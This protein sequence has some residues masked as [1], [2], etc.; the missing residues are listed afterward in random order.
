MNRFLQLAIAVAF[1]TPAAAVCGQPGV[2]WRGDGTGRYPKAHPVIHWSA[3]KNVVW[4]TELPGASPAS[5]ILVRDRLVVASDPAALLCVQAADGKVLWRRG[6]TAGDLGGAAAGAGD[7]S[8]HNPDGDAGSAASTPASDGR[9]VFAMFGNGVVSAHDLDGQRQWVRFIERPRTGYGHAS[10]PALAGGKVIV[11]FVDVVALEA[12]TGNEAWRVKLPATHASPVATRVG[13]VDVIVH[14]AGSIL[15]ASDGKALAEGLFRLDQSSPVVHEGVIY[16]H[17]NGT[18]KAFALPAR[19]DETLRVKPLWETA[20]P[21]GQYQIASPVLHDGCVYG[22]SLNGIWQATDGK[23]GQQ[24]YRH[25]L[26]FSAR[27]YASVHLAGG[28][29][30]VADQTGK[31]AVLRPG[32]SYQEAAVNELDYHPASFAFAGKRMYVRTYKH[33]YCVGE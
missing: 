6:H 14:P 25:R 18:L 27:V 26:P 21:R 33:L 9:H 1:L 24:I 2:G 29:L 30:F 7:V 11:Q 3:K 5:P 28:L 19:A 15:R 16:A 10:S 31:T 22:V 20:A 4:K 12:G 23:T 8:N 32:R 13:D 17:E